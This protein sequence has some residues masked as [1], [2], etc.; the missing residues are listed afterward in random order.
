[1]QK[2]MKG[3]SKVSRGDLNGVRVSSS[4]SARPSM[5][6]PRFALAAL[7]AHRYLESQA[8]LEGH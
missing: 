7:E 8:G 3:L 5:V 2:V 6:Q 4:S 1:M